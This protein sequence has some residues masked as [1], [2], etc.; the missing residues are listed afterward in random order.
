MHDSLLII[1]LEPL[2]WPGRL[3]TGTQHQAGEGE[4]GGLR[5]EKTATS[6]WPSPRRDDLVQL[7]LI[8]TMSVLLPSFRRQQRLLDL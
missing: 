7:T 5:L 2:R 4:S 1:T 3:V 8:E 6:P